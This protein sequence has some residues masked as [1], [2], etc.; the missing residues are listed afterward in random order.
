MPRFKKQNQY[1]TASLH[2]SAVQKAAAGAIKMPKRKRAE[3]KRPSS[4]RI[5]VTHWWDGVDQLLVDYVR[6]NKI[7]YTRVEVVSPTEIIIHERG[8]T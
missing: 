4:S 6:S 8:D 5:V 2:E 3:R 7:H 1:N